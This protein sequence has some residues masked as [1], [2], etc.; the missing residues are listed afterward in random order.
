MI[1]YMQ[2]NITEYV[3][4]DTFYETEIYSD[5]LAYAIQFYTML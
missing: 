3:I 1:Q 4:Y 5:V 2:H